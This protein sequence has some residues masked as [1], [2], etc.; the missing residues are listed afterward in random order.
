[1]ALPSVARP[2]RPLQNCSFPLYT[3]GSSSFAAPSLPH[4]RLAICWAGKEQ[5]ASCNI[6]R[7]A[8]LSTRAVVE[9]A[10]HHSLPPPTEFSWPFGFETRYELGEVLGRGSFGTVRV[11]TDRRNGQVLAVKIIPKTSTKKNIEPER[12]LHRIHEEVDVLQRIQKCSEALHLYEI[13]ESDSHVYLVT[14]RCLGGTLEDFIRKHGSCTEGESAQVAHDILRV[15]LECHDQGILYADVKPANFLLI[16][17]YPDA[18]K[19]NDGDFSHQRIQIKVA[20]FG[21]AQRVMEGQKLHKRTGTPLYMAPELFMQ[22]YGLES[23]MWALGILLYQMLAGELPFWEP[24]GDRSPWAIMTGILE[25]ELI[26]E[27]EK[28]ENVSE[29]AID[30]VRR[31]LDRDYSTRISAAEALQHPWILSQCGSEGCLFDDEAVARMP[32][33]QERQPA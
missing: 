33:L 26:F 12:I 13:F 31:L 7:E 14:D 25:G 1:M 18:Q 3:A 6:V 15:L 8:G 24:G 21:C 30:L 4:S 28:W 23:D 9:A 11:A 16:N 5:G 20:D 19:L 17:P 27:G 32:I 29:D 10:T 22:Y 2:S